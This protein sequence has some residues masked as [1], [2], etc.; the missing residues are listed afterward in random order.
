[1]RRAGALICTLVVAG[2]GSG[3][4]LAKPPASSS[5]TIKASASTVVYG[6]S[7][8]I[9][10][11]ATGKKNA[12]ATVTLYAKL[13][14]SNTTAKVVASTK[15][16]ASGAYSFTTAPDRN[17]MYFVKIHTAPEATSTQ[18]PVKV[19]VKVTLSLTGG[20]GHM[21]FSGSVLPNYAG[22]LVLIQRRRS[23]GGWK[24]VASATLKPASS[25]HTALGATTRSKYRKRLRLKSGTYRVLF[26][27][28]DGLRIANASPKRGI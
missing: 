23:S 2:A 3:L 10:G 5:V 16:S 15:T 4:A 13:A 7:V 9:T 18:V 17:T 12:G 19:A 8:T 21:F 22:K 27:P 28:A 14:P 25:V 26:N 20:A 1:M 6:S 11:A 24:K